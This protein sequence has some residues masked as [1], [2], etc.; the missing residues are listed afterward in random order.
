MTAFAVGDTVYIPS[1]LLPSTS[2]QVFEYAVVKTTVTDVNRT[3]GKGGNKVKVALPPNGTLNP[4]ISDWLP[5]SKCSRHIGIAIIAIGDLRTEPLLIEPLYKSVLQ[6]CRLLIN[7][8]D[9][10]G[11]RVRSVEELKT[12]AST[13]ISSFS[14]LVLIGHG[15]VDSIEFAVNGPRS[16]LDMRAALHVP[17]PTPKLCISLCCQTGDARF[18]DNFSR[19]GFCRF[20]AAPQ[21]SIAG[22]T[23]SLFCQAFLQFSLG[24]A[25]TPGIAFKSALASTP[26]N[27]SFALWKNGK[28]QAQ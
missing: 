2:Q 16:A 15:D 21:N 18:S 5:V 1:S 22:S 4:G 6:F 9:I 17:S 28:V 12:W 23:A 7:D 20:L 25:Q 13:R 10:E 3:A 24:H 8:S 27:H 19:A 11:I 14:H 26:G